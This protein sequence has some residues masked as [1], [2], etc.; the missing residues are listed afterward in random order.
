MSFVFLHISHRIKRKSVKGKFIPL[1]GLDR[2]FTKKDNMD[3]IKNVSDSLKL[4]VP[5]IDGPRLI[6]ING[7]IVVRDLLSTK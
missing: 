5:S 6:N 4:I 1:P 2:L 7:T 3:F